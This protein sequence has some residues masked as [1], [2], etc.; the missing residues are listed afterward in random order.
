VLYC[1]VTDEEYL[2]KLGEHIADKRRQAGFNQSQFALKC[3]MD[4][5]NLSRI[6]KG[7]KNLQ[8]LTLLRLANELNIP[9]KDL[10]DF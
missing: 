2:K 4:R 6:E 9:P 8:T 1:E 7:K 10:L 5:Q 3:D